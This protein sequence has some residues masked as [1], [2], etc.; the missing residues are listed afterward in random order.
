VEDQQ[1][2]RR[3][4]DRIHFEDDGRG[5]GV[6]AEGVLLRKE[7]LFA[8]AGTI[9]LPFRVDGWYNKCGGSYD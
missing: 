4:Q 6:E 9:V 2:L 3:S 7:K 5:A 1:S 8:L